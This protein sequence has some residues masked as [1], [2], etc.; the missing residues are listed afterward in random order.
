MS[1]STSNAFSPTFSL[2][3]DNGGQRWESFAQQIVHESKIK[4]H[5]TPRL[6]LGGFSASISMVKGGPFSPQLLFS[7]GILQ[8]PYA[9]HFDT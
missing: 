4:P 9:G 1:R 3:A 5:P 8:S 6:L 7:T 2:S